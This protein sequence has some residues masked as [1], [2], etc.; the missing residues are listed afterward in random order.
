M[1]IVDTSVDL[2]SFTNNPEQL[3]ERA[4]R[5]C[6]KSEDKITKDSAGSFI[7]RVC[8]QSKHES[9]ME[10][11]SATFHIICDRTTS[12]QIVRH[13]LA[14][15]SQES[16]RYCNYSKNKFDNEVCFIK[17]IELQDDWAIDEWQGVMY[18]AEQTYFRLL[19][20]GVKPEVARSV[21]PNSCK[22]EI[23]VTMNFRSWLHF[24]T[25]RTS[26]HAQAD[27]RHIAN[28]ILNRMYVLSPSIFK[29]LIDA[30]SN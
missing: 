30:R 10:H 5:N 27:I 1:K 26:K 4:A 23:V 19:G 24:L 11:A 3:I 17:P 9:V 25:L 12:H 21:L 18:E 8:M 20:Y 16:Q 22:T 2:I 6:Y 13:R 29:G 28:L 15:Y 7:E 14:S